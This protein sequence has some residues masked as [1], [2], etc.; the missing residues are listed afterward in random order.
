MYRVTVFV[1]AHEYAGRTGAGDLDEPSGGIGVVVD[2]DVV[3]L[4]GWSV[5]KRRACVSWVLVGSSGGWNV[6][7]RGGLRP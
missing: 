3:G 7:G 1:I 5:R 4:L 2:V 6:V